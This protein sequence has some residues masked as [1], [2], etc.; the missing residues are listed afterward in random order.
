MTTLEALTTSSVPSN[1]PFNALQRSIFRNDVSGYAIF[2]ASIN[3]NGGRRPE[4]RIAANLILR[5]LDEITALREASFCG[6]LDVTGAYWFIKSYN[7]GPPRRSRVLQSL[8]LS[9][10]EEVVRRSA[11]GPRFLND[12]DYHRHAWTWEYLWDVRE[13]HKLVL[14]AGL[15]N[16]RPSHVYPQVC[17]S[18]GGNIVY[19]WSPHGHCFSCQDP[20]VCNV[21]CVNLATIEW[22]GVVRC[23]SNCSSCSYWKCKPCRADIGWRVCAEPGCDVECCPGCFKVCRTCQVPLPESHCGNHLRSLDE[24]YTCSFCGLAVQRWTKAA[25]K[26]IGVAERVWAVNTAVRDSKYPWD[27]LM[28][29]LSEMVL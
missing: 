27:G 10:A 5:I 21:Y 26:V 20:P 19:S 8:D 11:I 3:L 17:L 15:P 1:R 18:C 7:D 13:L 14:D 6:R 2:V 25:S 4:S 9:D 12:D 16:L 22:S 28:E 23:G 29:V 24:F